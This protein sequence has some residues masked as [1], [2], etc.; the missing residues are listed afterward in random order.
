MEGVMFR[1]AMSLLVGGLLVVL[2]VPIG[3]AAI[4][5]FTDVPS[6]SVF[7]EDVAWLADS[8]VTR[9]CNPPA[10]DQFCPAEPVTRGQMAA[11]LHRLATARVVD[12]ATVGGLSADD[13]MATGAQA[14]VYHAYAGADAIPDGAT[15]TLATLNLSAPGDGAIQVTGSVSFASPTLT[16]YADGLVW[17]SFDSDLCDT[18]GTGQQLWTTFPGTDNATSIAAIGMDKGAHVVRL[19]GWSVG[20][21]PVVSGD[22]VVIWVPGNATGGSLAPVALNDTHFEQLREALIERHR[23]G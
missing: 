20:E 9:G 23:A 21:P 3:A 11:F 12:A 19:C 6:E 7:H 1:R 13:L 4:D 8:G 5:R 14:T 16:D 2:L 22:L 10:N 17:L 18:P 15:V